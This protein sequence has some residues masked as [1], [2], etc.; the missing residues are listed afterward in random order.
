M[1]E[2]TKA[3]A[4]HARANAAQ[5]GI[6]HALQ[7]EL[8]G[9]IQRDLPDRA[10]QVRIELGKYGAEISEP[11][12]EPV[13]PDPDAESD[14]VVPVVPDEDEDADADADPVVPDAPTGKGPRSARSR[15]P[16]PSDEASA[17]SED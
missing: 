15:V 1:S 7:T 9:Y 4:A 8:A 10:K 12:Q 14:P 6:I 13:V 11:D 17:S 16:A 2:T 5:S 3:E